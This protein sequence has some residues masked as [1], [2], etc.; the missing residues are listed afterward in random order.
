MELPDY[1]DVSWID[2]QVG[3]DEMEMDSVQV[4]VVTANKKQAASTSVAKSVTEWDPIML[5]VSI[6][7]YS[8]IV[9]PCYYFSPHSLYPRDS[10]I[11]LII[12]LTLLV[13]RTSRVPGERK[14]RKIWNVLEHGPRMKRVI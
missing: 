7:A 11:V 13:P 5:G 9:I 8:P 14:T 4:Q 10:S 2:K 12:R 6:F 3:D 1:E